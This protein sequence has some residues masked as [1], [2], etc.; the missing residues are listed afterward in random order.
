MVM[1]RTKILSIPRMCGELAF[2]RFTY[3]RPNVF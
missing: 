3:R 2:Y 1:D